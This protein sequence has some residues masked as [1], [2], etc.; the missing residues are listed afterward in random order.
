MWV[1]QAIHNDRFLLDPLDAKWRET[2]IRL[3][4]VCLGGFTFPIEAYRRAKFEGGHHPIPVWIKM[5]GLPYRFFKPVE[6]QR[7]AD[8]LSGGILLDVDRKVIDH[9]D[10]RVLQMKVGVCDKKIIPPLKKLKFV[11][12]DGEVKFFV[13]RFEIESDQPSQIPSNPW[14]QAVYWQ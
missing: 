3:A 9:V 10:F 13:M 14:D 1:A 7:I 8:S 6:Y 2:T 11:E 5:Y 12:D 4:E